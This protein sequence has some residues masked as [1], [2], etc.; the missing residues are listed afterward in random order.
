VPNGFP[1]PQNDADNIIATRH[2]ALMT[3]ISMTT[4]FASMDSLAPPEQ[5][6][7]QVSAP[8]ATRGYTRNSLNGTSDVP[9]RRSSKKSAVCPVSGCRTT[10]GRE[11]DVLRHIR[12]IHGSRERL[13]CGVPGCKKS[14]SRSGKLRSH[15]K[16]EHGPRRTARTNC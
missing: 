16:R 3:S 2:G 6:I 9:D 4:L 15:K 10:L 8:K 11:S 12:T 5:A 14:F 13:L 1:L 7:S